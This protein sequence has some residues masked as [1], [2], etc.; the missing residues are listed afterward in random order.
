[1][2]NT[3]R[4]FVA[5][6]STPP[7]LAAAAT[8]LAAPQMP[9]AAMR[10]A[11][12]VSASVSPSA[13]GIIPAAAIPCS[14]RQASRMPKPGASAHSADARVKPATL[15]RN[16]ERRPTTSASRPAGVS[17][18]AKATA[19]P[20]TVQDRSASEVPG[21]LLCSAGKAML[22]TVVSVKSLS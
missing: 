14:T 16:T 15:T 21:K 19:N 20:L 10:L 1:M 22:T 12:G 18:A 11:G 2:T 7:R 6:M 17:S 3:D 9:M 4:Q 13:E 8:E 5:L